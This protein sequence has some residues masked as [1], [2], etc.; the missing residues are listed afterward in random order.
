VKIF[1]ITFLILIST[2]V[3]QA[4][5]LNDARSIAD[6]KVCF[7]YANSDDVKTLLN[8]FKQEDSKPSLWLGYKLSRQEVVITNAKTAPDC[9]LFLKNA[10]VEKIITFQQPIP[11]S[12]GA[13]DYYFESQPTQLRQLAQ[14]FKTNGIK[15]AL[16][17]NLDFYPDSFKQFGI[18]RE[19]GS[20]MI[21]WS[22]VHEGLH[23][24]VQDSG[25]Y[26]Y[27]GWPM[28]D[29]RKSTSQIAT[30]LENTCY[31]G[32]PAIRAL[33]NDEYNDMLQ[34]MPLAFSSQQNQ[35]LGLMKDFINKRSQRYALVSNT[36]VDVHGKKISCPEMEQSYEM[37]EGMADFV[38]EGTV[39]QMGLLSPQQVSDLIVTLYKK[40]PQWAYY[41]LGSF[42]LL[43][44]SQKSKDFALE[45][46]K[47]SN[48]PNWQV[49]IDS[50]FLSAFKSGLSPTLQ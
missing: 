33:F 12:N 10:Q 13:F 16:V 41:P 43:I 17:W 9:A 15:F 5:A 24:F 7:D 8:L 48:S 34:A 31:S 39:I 6:S 49:N 32:N 28:A 20:T 50:E 22:M 40:A 26:P 3:A 18:P 42:K 46:S 45:V 38:G 47:L 4:K 27:P 14:A 25:I 21:F 29:G 36:T 30:D 11:L 44:L 19:L 37:V 2:F 1:K 23:L 35:M